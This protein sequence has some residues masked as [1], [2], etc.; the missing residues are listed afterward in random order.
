[1]KFSKTI[2]NTRKRCVQYQNNSS[3]RKKKYGGE[4]IESGG[5]GCLMKPAIKCNDSTDDRKKN[6][7]RVSKIMLKKY[8]NQEYKIC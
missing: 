5:F 1:M 6:R 3:S 7:N 2:K 4:V 8:A